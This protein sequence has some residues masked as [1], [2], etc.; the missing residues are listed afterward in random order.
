MPSISSSRSSC[1][2]PQFAPRDQQQILTWSVTLQLLLLVR[3][4][5]VH[6]H[7]VSNLDPLQISSANIRMQASSDAPRSSAYRG[8]ASARGANSRQ[9]S[10]ERAWERACMRG[11]SR[12][13]DAHP[14]KREGSL[15]RRQDG[16]G[17]PAFLDHKTYGF[18]DQ[19]HPPP[20]PTTLAL[21]PVPRPGRVLQPR[22]VATPPFSQFP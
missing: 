1:K 15:G 21:H 9:S 13:R 7:Y 3:A 12:E 16:A 2:F 8:V 4:Y 20:S 18:T 19:A 6:G 5:Q 17:M 14:R 22:L 11:E 10:S